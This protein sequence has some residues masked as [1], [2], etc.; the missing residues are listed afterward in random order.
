MEI[1][2]KCETQITLK[3]VVIYDFPSRL[4]F[5][6]LNNFVTNVVFVVVIILNHVH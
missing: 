5:Y 4:S 3:C 1:E 2:D 6:F